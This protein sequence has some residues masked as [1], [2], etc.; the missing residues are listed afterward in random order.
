[1]SWKSDFSLY[2][3]CEKC[4]R[5]LPKHVVFKDLDREGTPRCP[6]C[7]GKLFEEVLI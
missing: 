4:K 7:G 1:M 5:I 2:F 6:Y 3:I